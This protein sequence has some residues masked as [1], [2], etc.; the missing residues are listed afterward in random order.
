[1]TSEGL[2]SNNDKVARLNVYRSNSFKWAPARKVW[3]QYAY[4]NAHI[5]DDYTIPEDQANHG[6]EFFESSNDLCPATFQA[7]PLNAFNVQSTTFSIDGCPIYSVPDAE[8]LVNGS[9][10]DEGT[11][12]ATVDFISLNRADGVSLRSGI[13]I[14]FYDAYPYTNAAMRLS[15]IT[16]SGVIAEEGAITRG[17]NDHKWN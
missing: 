15:T 12:V 7:R 13:S 8:I 16:T 4:F 2:S 9:T 5:R 10:L 14:S 3:N 11:N 1:M 17:T 6:E